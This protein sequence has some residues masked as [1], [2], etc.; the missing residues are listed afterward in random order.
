MSASD[1]KKLRKEQESG[2]L[3]EKQLAAQKEAKQARLQ[4]TVFVI[5]MALI[6]VVAIVV[7]IRQVI[8]VNGIMEKKTT[9]VT[10]GSHAISNAELNYYYISSVNSVMS[11]YGQY[12]GLDQT[13]PLNQ[14][15]FDATTGKT[16]ADTFLADAKS[17]AQATYALC[18]KAQEAGYTLSD[19]GKANVDLTISN[20][21]A[22]AKL[23]GYSNSTAYLKAMYGNGASVDGYR[24][25]LE[26]STLA[27]EY[28]TYYSDSLT[29]PEAQIRE[30]DS[31]NPN[32]FNSYSFHSYYLAATRFLTGGTQGTDGTTTYTDEEKSASVKAAEEAAKELAAQSYASAEELDQ[33]IKALS[34]NA[35]SE[36]AA[37]VA[38]ADVSYSSIPSVYADWVT[39]TSRKTGDITCIPYTTGDTV[40]G[41]Y[42]VYYLGSNDNKFPLANVRHILVAFEGGSLDASTGVTTYSDEEKAAAKAEAEDILKEWKAG[43]ATE[44]SFAEL[45][46]TRSDDGDGTTGGLYKDIAPNSNYVENFKQWALD[47]HKPGDTGIVETQYGYHVMF[48]SGDTDYTYRDY[49]IQS[50]LRNEA[51]NTW[52]DETVSAATMVDGDTRYIRMDLTLGGNG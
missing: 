29:F 34:I 48:Y 50:Q 37:S 19:T 52:Y 21:E 51:M 13:V 17:T 10:I 7:G 46:N 28:E 35:D 25:F 30:L 18:D 27:Q 26:M 4:T 23:Y 14:Q 16:W 20:M 41:Y 32:A 11:S 8:N 2:K 39:D 9:A 49:L 24:H 36:T 22:Y 45:A 31:S 40:N 44:D 15:V 33:A 5:C 1:K 43:A 12:L 3:T 38:N 47:D 42:V 6:L